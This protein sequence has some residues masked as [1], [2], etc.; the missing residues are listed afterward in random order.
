MP[1]NRIKLTETLVRNMTRED[2]GRE[3]VPDSMQ[4]G[5]FLRIRE[6]GHKTYYVRKRVPGS[7]RRISEKIGAPFEGMTLAQA[8]QK[9]AKVIY[10]GEERV[11]EQSLDDMFEVWKV[12]AGLPKD[13]KDRT[14]YQ[15]DCVRYFENSIRT[16]FKLKPVT[17][18]DQYEVKAWFN[19][20]DRSKVHTVNRARS[21][22]SK[23][24]TI[25]MTKGLIRMNPVSAVKPLPE[26]ARTRVFNQ[27]EQYD[28]W[29]AIDS[30]EGKSPTSAVNAL[31][32]V[33]LMPMRDGEILQMRWDQ[34][35]FDQ[36]FWYL[37]KS[38]RKGNVGQTAPL[39]GEFAAFIQGLP[40]TSEE[41]VFPAPKDN[42][43]SLEYSVLR[44]A[45]EKVKPTPD[46]R[47]HDFR[48]TI[49]TD[50]VRALRGDLVAVGQMLGHTDFRTTQK[51]YLH[52]TQDRPVAAL[53]THQRKFMKKDD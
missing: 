12:D 23:L 11:K 50:A 45:W 1:E 52:L 14:Q 8:R 30:I 51:S 36:G 20:Q 18:I 24:L 13:P 4:A 39:T 41:W 46:S 6:S 17:A 9:A 15:K 37:P 28:V 10:G 49:A 21:M 25:A 16:H 44:R 31:R 33:M 47:M 5:L 22:L 34:F 32:C 43:K 42:T 53:E 29:A 48:R 7:K 40:K 35:D 27:G 2:A 19:K 38:M 3:Y 26:E